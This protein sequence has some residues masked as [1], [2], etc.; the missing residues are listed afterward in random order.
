MYNTVNDGNP[1]ISLGKDASDRFEIKTAYNSGAQTLDEVYFNSYTTSASTND[2]R[3]IFQVDEV[4][5]AKL[6]DSGLVVTGNV[7]ATD[8]GARLAATDTTTSSAT[9]G[10]VLRLQANDGAAMGDDHRLGLIEFKGAEDASSNYVVG[11]RIEAMCDAAWS[12]SENGAR[13]DFYTT[14]ADASESKVLTLDSDKL[15]TFAGDLKVTGKTTPGKQYRI[16]NASFRDDIGTSKHYMPQKSADENEALE[17][18]EQVAELAVMDGRL[19]SATV[20]VENM[21]TGGDTFDLTIGVETN[22]V[23]T[24]YAG[25]SVIET[26]TLTVNTY[27]DH[28]IFHFVFDTAKHWDSTDMFA[29]SIQSTEDHWGSNE[30]FF[31]TLV[32]EEDWNTYLG[33]IAEGVSSSEIDTTP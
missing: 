15:A 7:S 8:A 26:E 29:I 22:V 12:A 24:A 13:L 21:A 30:R 5:L 25:F 23:G 3:Y 10:G 28:H 9:Q 2:G 11:A 33:G 19:V 6:I 14:D 18:A 16:I 1:T 32:I 27:D 17:R 20:R 31:V 4:E